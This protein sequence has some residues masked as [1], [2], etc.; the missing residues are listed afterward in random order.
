[1]PETCDKSAIRQSFRAVSITVF[2][3][4][5]LPNM[6]IAATIERRVDPEMGCAVHVSGPLFPGDTDQLISILQS[7]PVDARDAELSSR[8]MS[9]QTSNLGIRICFDS[10]GGSFSEALAMARYIQSEGLGTAIPSGARCES[11]CAIAFMAGVSFY[12]VDQ[13]RGSNRAMH[14]T[15]RLGFHAPALMVPD[16][17]YDASQ[18]SSAYSL[19]LLSLVEVID[20]FGLQELHRFPYRWLLQTPSEDMRFVETVGEALMLEIEVIGLSFP[21]AAHVSTL[22]RA[23]RTFASVS[24]FWS[25]RGSSFTWEFFSE[26]NEIQEILFP[27]TQPLNPW[28]LVAA[29]ESSLYR[30]RE[31]N[32]QRQLQSD[33]TLMEQDLSVRVSIPIYDSSYGYRGAPASVCEVYIDRSGVSGSMTYTSGGFHGNYAGTFYVSYLYDP[34]TPLSEFT[35]STDDGLS[36]SDFTAFLVGE[37]RMMMQQGAH[38]GFDQSCWLTSPTA[39]ITNVSE[40]VNLRRQPDFAASVVRQVP[41]GER[42]R[43]QRADNITIIG[44]ERVRQSCI[45]ACQ[46]FGRNPGD[47]T[48]RDRAQQCIQDNML[49]YEITDARGNR[50]WVSRRF[51]EEVQ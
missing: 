50:G 13:S 31:I 23:C 30:E 33:L 8:P 25:Q 29:N 26:I 12:F 45:S 49:W 20:I 10:P 16:V 34:S 14:I 47:R 9:H 5:A 38:S 6:S 17:V 27:D 39:R 48:A 2:L 37:I 22:Q 32:Y 7:N 51:L 44:Q 28:I 36:H 4:F 18:I 46:A 1:M 21:N 3:P 42:V 19:S 15:A 24:Y 35:G 11:A 43:A 40:Y 41:L